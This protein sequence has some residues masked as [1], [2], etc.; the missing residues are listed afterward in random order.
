MTAQDNAE[1]SVVRL[2]FQAVVRT[3][4]EAVLA[5][6]AA[7]QA[8]RLLLDRAREVL[9][10]LPRP[11]QPLALDELGAAGRPE[12]VEVRVRGRRRP[13]AGRRSADVA[14]QVAPRC[15]ARAVEVALE[16][17]PAGALS[18]AVQLGAVGDALRGEPE[19]G[20]D[21]LGRARLSAGDPD[22]QQG[23]ARAD[24]EAVD[25]G[26]AP[27]ALGPRDHP[28]GDLLGRRPARAVEAV[29]VQA[30]VG[31][32]GEAAESESGG[33]G[34]AG[35]PPGRVA[36]AARP[37]AP[38]RAVVGDLRQAGA[39]GRDEA[40]GAAA[41]HDTAGRAGDRAAEVGEARPVVPV[42]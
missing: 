13:G 12:A 23:V 8:R 25:A 3:P 36:T 22:R 6:P 41:A 35:R 27:H 28:R 38:G 37:G 34:D 32:T 26:P 40:V 16:E 5:R 9:L 7:H 4:G 1:S 29:A 39:G 11:A 42:G 18:E 17:L 15:P 31:P 20:A 21:L 33:G 30:L 10:R 24:V 2:L 14:A 19:A